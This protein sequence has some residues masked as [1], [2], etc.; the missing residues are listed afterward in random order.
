MWIGDGIVLEAVPSAN[1]TV[2]TGGK[3]FH[4]LIEVVF[5]ED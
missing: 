5:I 4:A 3:P 2:V 1:S